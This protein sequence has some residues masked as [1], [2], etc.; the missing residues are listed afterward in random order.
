MATVTGPTTPT[1]AAET[2]TLNASPWIFAANTLAHFGVSGYLVNKY[3][4]L[5]QKFYLPI[6]MGVGV[7]SM[8]ALKYGTQALRW[9][10]MGT[11]NYSFNYNVLNTARGFPT[12]LAINALTSPLLGATLGNIPG[13]QTFQMGERGNKFSSLVLG[14]YTF[15]CM[16][17]A[18]SWG[19]KLFSRLG[20][21]FAAL[22]E[23]SALA[24]K[25]G[26]LGSAILLGVGIT[27]T[28]D[29]LVDLVDSTVVHFKTENNDPV[30]E[31]RQRTEAEMEDL[32]WRQGLAEANQSLYGKT[33]GGFFTSISSSIVKQ[34]GS[35]H[36]RF[37]SRETMSRF[38]DTKL[39]IKAEMFTNFTHSIRRQITEIL[40]DS[41]VE[42]KTNELLWKTDWDNLDTTDRAK[43][44]LSGKRTERDKEGALSRIRE[45]YSSY[46][47]L[48]LFYRYDYLKQE[49][50]MLNFPAQLLGQVKELIS[51][52]GELKT[53]PLLS[54]AEAKNELIDMAIN[55]TE[56]EYQRLE[57]QYRSRLSK[58]QITETEALANPEIKR[59]KQ[60]HSLR[61]LKETEA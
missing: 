32:I 24:S 18:E 5:P 47:N 33:A 42:G 16:N 36:Q 12:T 45:F 20:A 15:Y 38:A 3:P 21:R 25:G 48:K 49:D 51:E 6:N 34:I 2:T 39:A 30:I 22:T 41:M 50:L 29:L 53:S 43:K 23:G 19:A 60:L 59:Y 37:A 27:A 57:N 54:E 7:G 26:V 11:L 56:K 31:M 40:L 44:T 35:I 8:Y 10:S 61:K 9:A 1:S 28:A 46:P 17:N 4:E 52:E 55:E 14:L 58:N 13:L